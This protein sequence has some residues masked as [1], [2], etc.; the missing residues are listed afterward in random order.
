MLS[1]P[2]L[3]PTILSTIVSVSVVVISLIKPGL[4]KWVPVF[5]TSAANQGVHDGL[6]KLLNAVLNLALLIG[7]TLAMGTFTPKQ[8]P[9][10]FIYAFLMWGTGDTAYQAVT[11]LRSQNPAP[12]D[13]NGM[14][15]SPLAAQQMAQEIARQVSTAT[16]NQSQQ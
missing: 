6:L 5:N 11:K 16:T 1:L 8:L 3:D 7:F 15:V 9:A 14:T 12:V 2:T 10:D 4:E 13:A